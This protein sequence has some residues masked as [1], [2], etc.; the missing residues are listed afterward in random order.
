MLKIK[1]NDSITKWIRRIARIWS[2]PI[3]AY[4][5]LL[6]IGY[7]INWITTGKADPY[8][9][10]NYP[11]IENLPPLFMFFAILG[12]GL[13]WK[14]EKWGSII[15]LVFCLATLPILLIH[16]PMNENFFYII[17]Y[18]LLAIIAVPGI[19]FLACWWRDQRE[20]TN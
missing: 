6:F 4:A 10:E 2:V 15:N 17:P 19:L 11:F 5:L 16:W 12:S 18:I 8:A 14:K 1:N 7:T 13:A 20:E 9:S 3:I